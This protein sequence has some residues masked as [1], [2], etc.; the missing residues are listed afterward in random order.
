MSSGV[1]LTRF[2]SL[3]KIVSSTPDSWSDSDVPLARRGVGVSW[4]VGWVRSLLED[5]NRPRIE[6]IEQAEQAVYHNRAGMWG[7]HDQPDM[8]VPTIPKYAL[9]NVRALVKHFVLPLTSAL[10]AP[11]W[12]YVPAEQRGKPDFFVSHTWNSLLLG[13]HQ[14][15]IGTLDAIEHLDHYAWIDFIAYN[16]HTI[17]SIPTDMEAVIGEIGKVVFAG[18]PVPTLGRIWCLWE[19]LCANRT[20]IDFDIAIRPGYRNDKILAVNTLYRSFVGVEKAVATKP[21]DMKIISEEV[22]A[23]FGSAETANEHFDQILRERFSG[24]WYELRERDQHLGF[25]PWPWLYEQ[26]PGGEAL[27]NRPLR[28]P[29]PYYGA[30]IRDSAIYGSQQSTFDMLIEA[31]LKVS[32]DDMVAHEFRTS[33]EAEVALAETA[34]RGDL[35]RVRELLALG[36]DPD[37]PISHGS[38]LAHAAGEGHAAVVELLLESGADIEGGN[39]LSPLACAAWNGKDEIV[40]LLIE[41][42]ADIEGDAGGPGTALF[43]ACAQGHLSTVCLLLERGASVH[44]KTENRATPLLVAAANSRL[45]V[46]I[47]LIAAGADL[48]CTDRSGDTALHHAAHE[49]SAAIVQALVNAGADRTLVDKY[50]DTAFDIGKRE[51]RLDTAT[52]ELLQ[53]V[54]PADLDESIDSRQIADEAI[55]RRVKSADTPKLD[56][57]TEQSLVN[58][59]SMTMNCLRCGEPLRC[60]MR[61]RYFYSEEPD[62]VWSDFLDGLPRNRCTCGFTMMGNVSSFHTDSWTA[63]TLEPPKGHAFPAEIFAQLVDEVLTGVQR[64]PPLLLFQS[65]EEIHR[66][67]SGGT[68]R[69]IL[70]IPY[71]SLIYQDVSE[72]A[73]ALDVLIP[74]AVSAGLC[75]DAYLFIKNAAA[76]HPDIFL[77]FYDVAQKLV[78]IVDEASTGDSRLRNDFE[79]VSK[80]L[81]RWRKAPSLDREAVFVCFG[82]HDAKSGASCGQ[83]YYALRGYFDTHQNLRFLEGYNPCSSLPSWLLPKPILS[84][85]HKCLLDIHIHAAGELLL[86]HVPTASQ[87]ISEQM[88]RARERVASSCSELSEAQRT[89]VREFYGTV[90]GRELLDVI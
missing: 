37:Q 19:L 58:L 14:Q 6:V 68:L 38:A 51:G 8:E 39:G 62:S 31:G 61:P 64:R 77:V 81:A 86:R 60:F 44:T 42:G 72:T 33:S 71:S 70:L 89:Q 85:A 23:Q 75:A 25:R 79:S 48:D 90:G 18:T 22:L 74:A 24:S 2:P 7:L 3:G 43:Q 87:T 57:P 12:A 47:Q 15:E 13:P 54:L 67:V 5:I 49:G 76:I 34:R 73:R 56:R 46:V 32:S 45:D 36:T 55:L 1:D 59:A 29:D 66:A 27:A 41:R 10:R 4:L 21:E 16:Q 20:G 78:Q 65:F 52:L 28:E 40:R 11:L 26:S 53:V 83:T 9:L 69:P 80:Q 50:G 82:E 30:G 84:A 35:T 63:V 88:R 17:E